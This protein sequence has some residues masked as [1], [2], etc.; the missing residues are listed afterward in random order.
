M[1]GAPAP[2][3]QAV[4]RSPLYASFSELL[5][6]LVTVRAFSEERRFEREQI[7]ALNN[8]IKPVP[9]IRNPIRNEAY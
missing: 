5:A 3:L 8:H 1:I 9:V 2:P 4:A 7:R 6:G